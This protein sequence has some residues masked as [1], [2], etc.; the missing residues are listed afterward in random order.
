MS[1][2]LASSIETTARRSKRSREPD[3]KVYIANIW[4]RRSVLCL[5]CSNAMPLHLQLP[6]DIIEYCVLP[7]FE[8][9]PDVQHQLIGHDMSRL[10]LSN[11]RFINQ[12]MTR[13]I[14][15]EPAF[16][17]L[18][19]HMGIA[20]SEHTHRN[21]GIFYGWDLAVHKLPQRSCLREDIETQIPIMGNA[22][23]RFFHTQS[24]NTLYDT[25]KQ[26][27][28]AWRTCNMFMLRL[29]YKPFS[30]L[31]N[32]HH[33]P[34]GAC[35]ALTVKLKSIC[36]PLFALDTSEYETMHGYWG[37]SYIYCFRRLR[38]PHALQ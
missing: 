6:R 15:C 26:F 32:E 18:L 29:K 35:D 7:F 23:F 5:L 13:R 17:H 34:W 24:L 19:L 21:L 9:S 3:T 2:V 8:Q 22:V 4:D 31:W 38:A 20:V 33:V 36:P 1:Q 16:Q 30:V 11:C 10:F 37:E 12:S 28:R 27:C 25:S 14:S